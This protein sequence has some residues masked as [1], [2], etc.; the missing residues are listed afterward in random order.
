MQETIR[1]K[2]EKTA[3]RPSNPCCRPWIFHS[4]L[5]FSFSRQISP[6]A[7]P[8]F[9]PPPGLRRCPETLLRFF[10][11]L[12][13]ILT[14][15]DVGALPDSPPALVHACMHTSLSSPNRSCE[16][17]SKAARKKKSDVA[18][19]GLSHAHHLGFVVHVAKS[20]SRIPV[21]NFDIPARGAGCP[22]PTMHSSFFLSLFFSCSRVKPC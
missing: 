13:L 16:F 11:F 2:K 21:A 7:C 4:L 17:V 1:R 20:P 22:R 6:S 19:R 8:W 14:R 3:V 12:S 15:I 18:G 10:S 9:S 5:F